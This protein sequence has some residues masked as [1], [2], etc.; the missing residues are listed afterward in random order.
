MSEGV[1]RSGGRGSRRSVVL[2]HYTALPVVGGVERVI[3]EHARLL[4]DDGHA[5]TIVAGRGGTLD[6]RV[7]FVRIPLLH[8][9]HPTIV[10][11][12]ATLREGRVP[13]DFAAVAATI[14]T[15][16]RHALSGA[17]IVIAHNL[18]SLDV[19]LA[20]TA[21]L[22]AEAERPEAPRL[23]LWHHDLAP[24]Q[25]RAADWAASRGM[26]WDLIR[27][28][29]AGPLHV[30]ISESRRDEWATLTGLPASSIL[31]VP[32]GID[33]GSTLGLGRATRELVERLDAYEVAPLLLMPTRITPRKNIELGL[34]VTGA[35][36]TAGR[37]AG[38]LVTGP[39]DPHRDVGRGYLATLLA[40]RRDL[41]LDDHAWF[42]SESLPRPPT[43]AMVA[44][45][46]RLSDALFLPS[47]DE[48]FGLP[49]L[50]AAAGR[51]PILCA[52]LPA[53]RQLAGDAAVY[54]APDDDPADIAVRILERLDGD[55]T[56]TLARRVRTRLRWEVIYRERIVPLLGQV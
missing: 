49:I 53:L 24:D 32:N 26:P 48:G 39:A 46:Y 43:G 1:T 17:D 38:L 45:L 7:R 33:L 4:A 52:D 56:C 13:S 14:G 41:R 3:A 47:R 55:P 6:A 15:E 31:V 16:L 5:V 36:R 51:L 21:A 42:L 37:P 25:F 35:L 22:R 50:E 34:R 12:Q 29:W 18:A 44:D 27:T 23:V 2:L 8:T 19:N 11:L 28:P 10:R 54:F 9:Q 40:L 30:T 20:L